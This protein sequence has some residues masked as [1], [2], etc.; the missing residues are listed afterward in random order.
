MRGREEQPRV[1][2]LD[3]DRNAE[4]EPTNTFS[5]SRATGVGYL[6]PRKLSATLLLL[7][8]TVAEAA[9][10]RAGSFSSLASAARLLVQPQ[11]LWFMVN[12]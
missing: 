5:L 9:Q 12:S 11:R 8:Y 1:T 7:C 2:H 6:L 3:P 10:S 4:V